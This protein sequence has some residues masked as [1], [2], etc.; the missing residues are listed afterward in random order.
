MYK[1]PWR[2]Q[3]G[4][5]RPSLCVCVK[6]KKPTSPDA[7]CPCLEKLWSGV[8]AV[9]AQQSPSHHWCWLCGAPRKITA[10]GSGRNLWSCA[11]IFPT[12]TLLSP[13]PSCPPGLTQSQDGFPVALEGAG[14][15]EKRQIHSGK[16][17]S[18]CNLSM[19]WMFAESECL[20]FE[21]SCE[22]NVLFVFC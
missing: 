5:T 6:S 2:Q 9:G 13:L 11:F 22:T 1:L 3:K 16:S 15:A 10:I 8:A 20:S 12:Q 21:F 19:A 4:L 17:H 14:R 7:A 18:I